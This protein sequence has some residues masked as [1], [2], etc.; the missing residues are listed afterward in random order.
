MSSIV[1]TD[2][3][4]A[5]AGAIPEA[6]DSHAAVWV[7]PAF[8]PENPPPDPLPSS[9]PTTVE[10]PTIDLP[11][12]GTLNE[13]ASCE[14]LATLG[15]SYAQTVAYW[16]RYDMPADLDPDANGLPCEDAYPPSDVTDVYGE[17]DAYSVQLIA[18]HPTQTFVATGPAVEA[19]VIC[20]TGSID[21]TDNPEAPG[22]GVLSR[23]EDIYTCEDNSGTF[24]LG[25]DEYI[26]IE[27]AMYGIW[28]IVSGT[29]NY[30]SMNGGGGTDGGTDSISGD[31]DMSTGRL[32]FPTDKN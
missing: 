16:T 29:G 3:G 26:E 8:D 9:P 23:W 4:I 18:S 25:V 30:E 31:Y 12:I 24:I 32:W 14:E 6:D 1:V 10:E 22:L 7:G 20:A 17:P 11:E 13:G 15:Y 2:A 19:G 5:A 21:Y 28:K 27:P